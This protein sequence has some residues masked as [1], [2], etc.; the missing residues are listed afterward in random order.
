MA[1]LEIK[2][3]RPAVSYPLKIK[4]GLLGQLAEEIQAV[5]KG[6]KVVVITDENVA[7]YYG[8]QVTTTLQEA[9]YD[10]ELIVLAPG[11]A[12]KSIEN[13]P[14]LYGR[15][16]NFGISRSDLIIALG[17]G[18]IGDLAGFV[19]ASFLRGI[20]LIQVPT[21][22]LAQVDSSVGGKV[23]V[24]LKEGKNLV[25]AFY[26]PHSV[27]IDPNVLETLSDKAFSDGM[28]EV[29]K[30]G[31]IRD[32]AFFD[33]L[34]QAGN[35]SGVMADIER[36]LE[37]CCAIKQEVVEADEKDT[38]CR[39]LL[40]YGHTLGHAIEA[41]YQYER[42]T[43]GEGVA[44]GMLAI[45]QL[46]EDQGLSPQGSTQEIYQVVKD[47][48]LPTVLDQVEDYAGILPLIKNDKKN[49]NG[50]LH[51]ITLKRIGQAEIRKVPD[52]F[53]DPLLEGGKH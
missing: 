26:H 15:L 10:F 42:Y 35:R 49:L 1:E 44:I 33:K 34:K 29:I 22:L 19:A 23:A 8:S 2:L 36:I 32:R 45:N 7:H 4:K 6:K 16:V 21:T 28:A 39:M 27:L 41:Y 48:G 50:Q 14:G 51:I 17:G 3:N 20:H 47:F 13:L 31:C 37:R 18:V 25:G 24:D 11:E 43:H 46:A 5:H 53:F 30:Y 40:N 9:G 52:H 38:G 12:S